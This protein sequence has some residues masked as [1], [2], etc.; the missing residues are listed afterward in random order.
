MSVSLGSRIR[1]IKSRREHIASALYGQLRGRGM[2][3]YQLWPALEVFRYVGGGPSPGGSLSGRGWVWGAC[4]VVIRGGWEALG[5]GCVG[6]SVFFSGLKVENDEDACGWE[7]VR[8]G[9][10]VLR[11]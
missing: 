6:V 4:P 11:L 9:G 3:T 10:G 7:Q 2:P 5:L 8:G 1:H